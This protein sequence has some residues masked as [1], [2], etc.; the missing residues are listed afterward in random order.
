[1]YFYSVY[2]FII[3]FLVFRPVPNNMIY[4]YDLVTYD[5]WRAL[6]HLSINELCLMK[7]KLIRSQIQFLFAYR[8]FDHQ[9]TI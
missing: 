8:T 4:I 3:Y 1:M 2:L 5:L 6:K 7:N 9:N